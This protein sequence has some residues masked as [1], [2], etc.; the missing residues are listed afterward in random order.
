MSC[1]CK[2]YCLELFF[3]QCAN[4]FCIGACICTC[5]SRDNKYSIMGALSNSIWQVHTCIRVSSRGNH[6][7]EGSSRKWVWIYIL[8][9]TTVPNSGGGG[10][11]PPPPPMKPCVCILKSASHWIWQDNCLC[12]LL[13]RF[14]Y[15]VL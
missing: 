15:M 2:F 9:Y 4:I 11:F 14:L 12:Y 13:S 1:T 8:F 5:S 7:E 3:H 10:S 6:F